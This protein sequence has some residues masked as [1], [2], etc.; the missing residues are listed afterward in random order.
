[1]ND[2]TTIEDYIPAMSAESIA[3]A[4]RMTEIVLQA[5]QTKIATEHLFHAG[6]YA[7]TIMIYAEH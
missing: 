7:R 1:M 3:I 4:Q 5:Q 2:L 6:L